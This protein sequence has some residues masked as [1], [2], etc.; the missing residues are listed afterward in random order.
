M[1]T[2]LTYFYVDTSKSNNFDAKAFCKALDVD[3]NCVEFCNN[4]GMRICKNDNFN[5]DINEMVRT[6]LAS[7]WDKRTQLVEL[8]NKYN[9]TYYL[10]R[11]P[12]IYSSCDQP[13]PLLSLD[14]D[15]VAF[16]YETGTID[17]LDYY[18]Y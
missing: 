12:H 4:G 9:L 15:I 1:H 7:I 2:C 11:V 8:K 3:A 5:V 17:D 10:A 6:T 14:A 13:K 16:L 18:V